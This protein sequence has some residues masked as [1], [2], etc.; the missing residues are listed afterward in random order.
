MPKIIMLCGITIAITA[1]M[2][3]PYKRVFMPL[4]K[5]LLVRLHEIP[6]SNTSTDTKPSRKLSIPLERKNA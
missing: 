1:V 5:L 2:I 6:A 4:F 3:S